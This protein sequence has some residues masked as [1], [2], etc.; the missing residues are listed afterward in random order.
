MFNLDISLVA[1]DTN[2]GS[3]SKVKFTPITQKRKPLCSLPI[4]RLFSTCS[5][6]SWIRKL[7]TFQVKPFHPSK[8]LT[9]RG[10]FQNG[11]SILSPWSPAGEVCFLYQG[12]VLQRLLLQEVF[13]A[14]PLPLPPLL[15]IIS[16]KIQSFD[17]VID[18]CSK[19]QGR[20]I[21]NF[22]KAD[23]HLEAIRPKCQT[24]IVYLPVWSNYSHANHSKKEKSSWVGL[25]LFHLF[26]IHTKKPHFTNTQDVR[27]QR[28]I[29]H[30][31]DFFSWCLAQSDHMNNN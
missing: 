28:W 17:A 26:Y 9:L 13:P 20:L 24:L 29:K 7:T 5:H 30:P 19:A 10:S 12:R 8:N 15:A 6:T 14:A 2:H 31:D 23:T 3:T 1:Q 4:S 25:S 27:Q 21:R 18:V 11:L 16:H 22:Q